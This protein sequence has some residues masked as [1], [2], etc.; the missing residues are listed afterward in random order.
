MWLSYL[1]AFLTALVVSALITPVVR[2]YALRW[3]LGDKPNG[4]RITTNMIP[5][6]GG[7]AL[8]LGS[9]AGVSVVIGSDQGAGWSPVLRGILPALS[10]IVVLG[11]IDDVKSLR[12]SQKLTV[13]VIAAGI[14]VATGYCLYT[15]MASMDAA[16]TSL[17]LISCVFFVGM[18]SAVNFV[19]GHDGLA[20][21][22]SII[23]AGAFAVMALVVGS[24]PTLV[25]SLALGG[26]CLGFL[27]FNFPPGRIFMGDTGSMFLGV[28]LA[29]VACSLTMARPSVATFVGVCFVLGVPI[30]DVFLAI[31]RRLVL[32]TPVFQADSLHMHHVLTHMGF[33]PR[34]VLLIIYSMQTL[35]AVVG[36]TAMSGAILPLILGCV[37]LTVG[38]VA[39]LK[40]M[41]ASRQTGGRVAPAMAPGSILL[42]SNLRGNLPPQRTSAGR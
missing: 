14:L 18:A 38:F 36:I 16:Q 39:F 20:A 22:V 32:K 25:I 2:K 12:A 1:L 23:S 15:G 4:R 29:V 8:V 33:S 5:H 42:K 41:V 26:A 24:H 40:M 21:G 3:K 9:F 31:A 17:I 34:Q 28:A 35:F 27:V 13:Q 7:I 10:L 11:L 37:L 19:D 6:L 30:L